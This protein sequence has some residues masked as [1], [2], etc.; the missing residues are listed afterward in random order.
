MGNLDETSFRG[1]VSCS[2]GEGEVENPCNEEYTRS[3]VKKKAGFILA[4]RSNNKLKREP[5]A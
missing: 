1:R 5:D 2:S 3:E 4:H